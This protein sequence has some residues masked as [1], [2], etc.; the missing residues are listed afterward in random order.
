[1]TYEKVELKIDGMECTSCEVLL[2]RKFKKI[3]GVNSVNVNH[4]KG[5]ATLICTKVPSIDELK[6]AIN[7]SKYTIS[8]EKE[9]K[10]KE[11]TNITINRDHIEIGAIFLI[12]LA[13][14]FIFRQF[15]ILPSLGI[16]NNMSY[17]F[18]FL[19]G[20][21]A[22]FST[23]M[24]VSGGL[25]LAVSTKYNELNPN[26]NNK[27][28]FR[29]H[30]YFNIGRIISYTL[31]GGLLGALGSIF[32]I[33]T[34][35][36]GIITIVASFVMIV[37]GFQL[38]NIF[39]W[40]NKFKIKMPKF[41]AHKIHD[42]ST[43]N[44]KF[45]SF[46]LGACTFFLPCGFTQALQ[47]YV[48]SKGSFLVGSLT[49]LSF[50][51]GT[52]PALISVGAISSFS[53]SNFKKYFTKFVAVLVIFFGFITISSGLTLINLSSNINFDSLIPS[54]SAGATDLSGNI[55]DGKQVI[56]MKVDGYNYSPSK[57][58]ILKGMP[59]EWRIDAKNAQGCAQIITAPKFGITKQLSK[60]DINIIK[61]TPQQT[62]SVKFTCTMGMA[63]PGTFNVVSK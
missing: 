60:N 26:L 3:H 52:L 12:I 16:S 29:P 17:G 4:T 7:D 11:D 22:A 46:F 1:M 10:S 23:C 14:Y 54:A 61:F 39:P 9:Q 44:S 43:S 20:I 19:I 41:I 47:F 37:L 36:T 53:T 33:S 13:L 48:L 38:L 6:N 5:K 27:Q 58:N 32:K 24:A 51:L 63:G 40:F 56:N 28:K 2:E 15:D 59:V 42:A 45:A 50:S 57:F 55:I 25:L 31:L 21:V 8:L 18:I 30:I 34:N 62:G 49:M 35:I